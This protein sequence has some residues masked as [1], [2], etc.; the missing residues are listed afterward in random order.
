MMIETALENSRMVLIKSSPKKPV[1]Y[2]LIGQSILGQSLT[3]MPSH[4]L[5]G[6][7]FA[8]KAFEMQGGYPISTVRHAA[9][10]GGDGWHPAVLPFLPRP[11]K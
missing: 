2:S 8:R 1:T 4:V 6:H 3:P 7:F 9:G 10:Q 11:Q 5:P